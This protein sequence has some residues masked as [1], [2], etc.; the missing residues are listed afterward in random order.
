MA[1]L[2]RLSSAVGYCRRVRNLVGCC[3]INSLFEHRS[4][5]LSRP[6]TRACY[7]KTIYKTTS[8]LDL[9]Y[10]ILIT[11]SYTYYTFTTEKLNICTSKIN[12]TGNSTFHCYRN[13]S[14]NCWTSK[15][16]KELTKNDHRRSLPYKKFPSRF[17]KQLRNI[18]EIH[19]AIKK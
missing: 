12:S 13:I 4:P 5:L 11:S 1:N 19:K 9:S 10:I 14:T 8:V 18:K 2:W 15:N 6:P 17:A 3:L 16:S 7:S